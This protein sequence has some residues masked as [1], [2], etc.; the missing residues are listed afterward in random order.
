[1]KVYVVTEMYAGDYCAVFSTLEKA[2]AFI[3]NEKDDSL[4]IIPATI[5]G[6]Q[7]ELERI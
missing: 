6:G 4:L 1:M 5:D 3:A 2:E 7:W